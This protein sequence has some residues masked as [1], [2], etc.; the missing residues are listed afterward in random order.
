MFYVVVDDHLKKFIY[1]LYIYIYIYSIVL[2]YF[3]YFTAVFF[4]IFF[5][6]RTNFSKSEV[7][8]TRKK[9]TKER[10]NTTNKKDNDCC[11]F[12]I[13]E[14]YI[15]LL[16]LCRPVQAQHITFVFLFLKKLPHSPNLDKEKFNVQHGKE[17]IFL[18][19]M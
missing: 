19:Q 14:G 3:L 4:L 5:P 2:L 12:K 15:L 1:N 11:E 18:I 10:V 7:F 6:L 9:R 16:C 8:E 13:R 17:F